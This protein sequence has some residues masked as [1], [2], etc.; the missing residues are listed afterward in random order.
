M[1]AVPASRVSMALSSTPAAA[2]RATASRHRAHLPAAACVL[3][4][5][6]AAAY[7]NTTAHQPEHDPVCVCVCRNTKFPRSGDLDN[8]YS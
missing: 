5:R 2:A 8:P 3:A 6:S 1:S 4:Q 7:G